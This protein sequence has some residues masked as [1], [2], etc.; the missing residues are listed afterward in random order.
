MAGLAA[1]CSGAAGLLL[2][3]N[4]ASP[5]ARHGRGRGQPKKEL[6][7]AQAACLVP[8]LPERRVVPGVPPP[9]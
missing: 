5:A 7:R 4:G 6:E 1:P 8:L 3:I 9:W 2:R